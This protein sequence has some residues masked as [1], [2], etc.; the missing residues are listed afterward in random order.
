MNYIIIDDEPLAREGLQI[1]LAQIPALNCIGSFGNA[2]DATQLLASEK[3]DLVFLDINMP[4]LNGLDFARSL[5]QK[6]LIIFVTAYP[7]YA[8]D[9]YELDAVDYLVKPVRLPRLLKAVS[10]AQNYL[11]LLAA[12]PGAGIETINDD[13]IFVKSERKFFKL[14][15]KDIRYIEGLKDYVVIQSEDKKI[16]AAVN[17]KTISA[18]LPQNIFVRVSKSFI[19]NISHIVSC[20][21]FTI[22]LNGEEIPIG[23]NYKD[24]FMNRYLNGKI[25]KR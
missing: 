7:Q 5:Q 25:I 9:S 15:F 18:Q 3:A 21:A 12:K 6:P 4:Q 10:K 13:F 22:Y 11:G 20:D 19:V 24:E 2:L 23:S 16:I 14:F 1:S 8:L 17:I